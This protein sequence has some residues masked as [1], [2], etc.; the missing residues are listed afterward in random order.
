[1]KNDVFLKSTNLRIVYRKFV[2]VCSRLYSDRRFLKTVFPLNM[3][4]NLDLQNPK[5]FNEKMQWLK[6]YDRRPEYSIMV[7]K[8]RVKDYVANIIGESYI[9][10]TLA[11]YDR[12]SDIDI[13]QL[14]EKFVLKCTHDSGSIIICT[15]KSKFDVRK[16]K[17][18]LKKGLK[19]DFYYHNREWPYKN[20]V[21]KII[22]EPY[23]TDESGWQ[24]KDYKVF[25]FN[26]E[27]KYIEVDY[28]RYLSHKLNVYDLEWNFVDFYMTSPNDINC[29][30][31][32]PQNLDLMLDLAKKLSEGLLFARIDF[33]SI[34]DKILFGE[35]TFTPGSGFIDFHPSKYDLLLGNMLDLNND[36]K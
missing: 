12:A 30:I 5:T 13:N 28:D 27:P 26:G 8:Y 35:I 14:P 15:D 17:H 2:Y 25:C 32:K 4:Y 18:A 29:H 6:L 34:H 1:M 33:Y 11:V 10:P 3:G 36:K 21:K 31:D 9:I 23:L 7:D 22:A 16:A 19:K 20:V 24:L